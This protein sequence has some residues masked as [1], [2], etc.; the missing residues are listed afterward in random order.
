MHHLDRQCG[1]D[2]GDTLLDEVL[3]R[4][5]VVIG[6]RL[7]FLHAARIVEREVLEDGAQLL[8]GCG[9]HRFQRADRR[10]PGKRQVPLDL[11]AHAIAN[12]RELA[13]VGL[14]APS[15]RAVSP[16]Y[17]ASPRSMPRRS[18]LVGLS[19]CLD[20]TKLRGI[21]RAI[22]RRAAHFSA[23]GVTEAARAARTRLEFVDLD[24]VG[25]ND[26]R[27]NELCDSIARFDQNRLI[28]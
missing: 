6:G 11:D 26:W 12:Q 8:R 10:M 4:L 24:N 13:E 17:Q 5:D 22:E 9:R 3:D 21:A 15:A 1:I 23:A 19:L 14:Q 18:R 27:N 25:A 7:E 16:V 20:E 2:C 28:T